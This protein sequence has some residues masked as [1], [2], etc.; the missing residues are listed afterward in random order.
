MF[1]VG[2]QWFHDSL[3][4]G[5][6]MPEENY[7]TEGG[8]AK[9]RGKGRATNQKPEWVSSLEAFEVPDVPGEDFLSDCK[10]R[11]HGWVYHM[12]VVCCSCS[13]EFHRWMWSLLQLYLCGFT[14]GQMEKLVRVV[15]RGGGV[16]CGLLSDVVSHVVMGERDG[17][18]LDNI[19][20]MD[21]R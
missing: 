10:V 15:D 7:A 17:K 16:R 5:Y 3:E 6:C 18:A 12:G 2:P 4:T 1:C 20:Q 11:G 21:S 19:Q 14:E 8:V 9:G 13:S